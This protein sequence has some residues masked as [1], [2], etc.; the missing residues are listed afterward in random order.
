MKKYIK[1]VISL[2]VICAVVAALLA[3]TNYVTAP[4]IEKNASSAANEALVIVMPEGTDFALVD[5]ST[6]ELPATVTEVHSEASGGYVVKLTTAGY[7]TD[8]VIMC[9][10][11][12]TGEI[13]GATCLSSNETLGEEKDYGETALGSKLD[14]IDGLAT[15]A[16]VT[17]TTAGYKNALKDALNAAVI[18]SGGSADIK[19]DDTVAD[20]VGGATAST[21]ENQK[22]SS[23]AVEAEKGTE[24][25]G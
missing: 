24:G 23:K 19:N 21:K 4:I 8:M 3:V 14:S 22:E 20:A 18:F 17:K 6:Y 7:G 16:G 10:V 15:V 25:V 2:T 5:I 11:S 9:G 13:T 1:S 12:A